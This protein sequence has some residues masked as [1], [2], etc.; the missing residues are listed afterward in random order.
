[1]TKVGFCDTT[2]FDF[3]AKSCLK[4]ASVW[5][6]YRVTHQVGRYLPLTSKQ[7]LCF[8]ISSLYWNATYAFMSTGGLVLPDV[9]PCIAQLYDQH[10]FDSYEYLLSPSTTHSHLHSSLSPSSHVLKATG[11]PYRLYPRFGWHQYRGSVSVSAPCRT[12]PLF[13]GLWHLGYNLNG[14]PVLPHESHKALLF[15][16]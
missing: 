14:H 12:Q 15:T 1:M 3:L 7:K 10:I 13:W 6:Y 9:S 4:T 16:A 11:W 2:E 5:D 8:S